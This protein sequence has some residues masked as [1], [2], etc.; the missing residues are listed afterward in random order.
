MRLVGLA[1][2]VIEYAT[3]GVLALLGAVALTRRFLSP[4]AEQGAFALFLIM[5]A[6]FY[7]AFGAYFGAGAAWRVEIA[8]VVGFSVMGLLGTRVPLALIAGYAL[9]GLWDALHELG[10]AGVFAVFEPGRLTPV[11]LAYGVFCAA[12]DV[13]VAVYAF[14]RRADW[15]AARKP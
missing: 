8:A 15:D 1:V 7:L 13:G 9:H 3:I 14:R 11:P 12:F 6:A 4:R 5:I 10:A 2:I